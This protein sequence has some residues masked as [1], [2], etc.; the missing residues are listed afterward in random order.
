MTTSSSAT[1]SRLV[2]RP[3][4]DALSLVRSRSALM[5]GRLRSKGACQVAANDFVDQTWIG[6]PSRPLASG[7][8]LYARRKRP[9]C[10]ARLAPPKP[11][12]GRAIQLNTTEPLAAALVAGVIHSEDAGSTPIV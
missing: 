9:C 10:C 2:I 3:E 7:P 12:S 8:Y 5:S 6:T 4:S 1:G 11:V